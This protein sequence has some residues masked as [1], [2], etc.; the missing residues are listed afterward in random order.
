M[1]FS[2]RDIGCHITHAWH[3][4]RDI[5]NLARDYGWN[6]SARNE[7]ILAG[8]DPNDQDS[9]DMIRDMA[10]DALAWLNAQTHPSLIWMWADG[11]LILTEKK[12]VDE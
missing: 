3:R 10:D 7:Y 9:W 12:E 8:A 2:R 11:D 5:A 1:I 6:T 4:Y